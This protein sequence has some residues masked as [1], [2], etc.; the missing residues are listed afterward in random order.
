MRHSTEAGSE[1]YESAVPGPSR[2]WPIV[3]FR[4]SAT[5][6]SAWAGAQAC[7]RSRLWRIYRSVRR[8][9]CLSQLVQRAVAQ[10]FPDLLKPL[11]H[12]HQSAEAI[13]AEIVGRG[14]SRIA[15]TLA[16]TQTGLLRHQGFRNLLPARRCASLTSSKV[17]SSVCSNQQT[18]V[19]H[20]CAHPDAEP[21]PM[22]KPARIASALIFGSNRLRLLRLS[23][24]APRPKRPRPGPTA[25]PKGRAPEPRQRVSAHPG[26]GPMAR[27]TLTT[28]AVVGMQ[29]RQRHH[30][31]DRSHSTWRTDGAQKRQSAAAVAVTGLPR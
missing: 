31:R 6:G 26:D 24:G 5:T 19:Q 30:E 22:R 20:T 1:G 10:Y 2:R 13:V 11:T 3:G 27:T 21:W 4:A 15:F 14:P 8:P 17:S 23:F 9:R 12:P 29:A 7:L 16:A 25:R 18:N 28:R